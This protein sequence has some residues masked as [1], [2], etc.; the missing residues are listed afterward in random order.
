VTD[1]SNAD[2][3][4]AD[5]A[6]SPD[7]DA[8]VDVSNPG[9]AASDNVDDATD[10]T[11]DRD[12]IGI[13]GL[14]DALEDLGRPLT[15]ASGLARA[16]SITQEEASRALDALAE[17]GVVE[18]AAV[19]RDPVVWY[20]TDWTRAVDRERVVVFPD[21]REIIVDKPSQFTRARLSTFAHL[22]TTTGFESYLY[23][24]R[25][26]DV[27]H[28]PY[29]SL[30]ALLDTVRSVLRKRSEPLEEWIETQWT[31]ANQFVLRTH[32]EGY[33]VLEAK[34]ADLMGNVARQKLA[35]DQL[36]ATLSDTESWAAEEATAGIKRSLYEAGYPVRDERDLEEGDPLPISLDVALREYQAHW[37]REFAQK[38]AGV[39]VGPPGSGKTIA[40]L[41]VLADIEGESLILVPSRELA[42]QWREQILT[43]TSLSPEQVGEYHGGEKQIRPVT[44]ATYQTAGMDRH[45]QLFDQRR[46]G[47]IV[48][49]ECQH[50]PSTVYRRSADLQARHR[51][52]LS[53]T[54]IRED[55]MEAEIYTLIGPPI[56]ADW[57][58][59]FEAGFVAEPEVEIR[60]VPWDAPTTR[61]EHA[62]AAA[63]HEKRKLAAMNPAKLDD[64]RGLRTSHP[65][66]KALVF[67]EYLDH[68]EALAEALDA[69]FVS[70]GTAHHRRQA[71]LGEFR[72]GKRDTLV[73]SRVGDEGIDLPN[74]QLAI[75][76][77]G[78]GGSRRQGTQ[79]AGRTM[80]P[81]GTA[82]MYVLATRGTSEEEFAQRQ[83][84]HLSA[85]GVRVRERNVE[86]EGSTEFE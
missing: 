81:A 56:G 75:V 1:S 52:G 11:A 67:C 36:R 55:E 77:S 30:D 42:A 19:D 31:R 84:H 85:K 59:L 71:L 45:R 68:G 58:S 38:R 18:R 80:R 53:A 65:D 48:Y 34:S 9:S 5:D 66:A 22:V 14:Y 76:A 41:G 16:L 3:E 82:T 61:N 26:E 69:P 24:L 46:W 63:G 43:Q 78:L 15:T 47:L 23:E 2:R 51:L 60:Y 32:S 64:V 83:M 79:R 54:P 35:E 74:A 72:D 8:D 6:A 17:E 39:F 29:D 20:P 37:V 4:P 40:A 49:D 33:T 27:W 44:I 21:R 73:V 10:E 7:A 62:S 70:G 12:S 86:G 28:A 57:E 25:R 50:I 13:A